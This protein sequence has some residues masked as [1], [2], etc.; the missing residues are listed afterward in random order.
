VTAVIEPEEEIDW[1]PIERMLMAWRMG[2]VALLLVLG[3]LCALQL[4]RSVAWRAVDTEITY[5]SGTEYLY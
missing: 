4:A 2:M 1:P 5:G 3:L